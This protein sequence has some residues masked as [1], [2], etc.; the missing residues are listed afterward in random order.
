MTRVLGLRLL[1]TP[2]VGGAKGTGDV[3]CHVSRA[4]VAFFAPR[5]KSKFVCFL[6][7]FS[8]VLAKGKQRFASLHRDSVAE[9][10]WP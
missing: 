1:N 7:F 5:Q 4:D 3:F 2:H 9:G 8:L 6:S 10:E